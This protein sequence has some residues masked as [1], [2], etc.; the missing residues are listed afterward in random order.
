M[1]SAIIFSAGR[2]ERLY[3]LTRRIPKALCPI[4]KIPV[5]EYHIQKLKTAGIEQVFINHAYLGDQIKRCLGDGSRFGLDIFYLSEPP[6]GLETGGTMVS[7]MPYL[8]PNETFIAI[9]A[10]IYTDYDFSKLQSP[11]PNLFA[12]LVLVPTSPIQPKRDFGLSEQGQ[13]TLE[14]AEFIF[15]GIASYRVTGFSETI[16]GRFSLTPLLRDWVK[17]QKISGEIHTGM[18]FDIGTPER[19]QSLNTTLS[20]ATR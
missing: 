5:I 9:N 19:L 17:H 13:L 7:L 10:D 12:H 18:W 16:F 2:G 11:K 4:Q 8:S 20:L 15:S 14:P 1:K 6:G 3:P